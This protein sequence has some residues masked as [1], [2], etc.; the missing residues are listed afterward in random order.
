MPLQQQHGGHVV[1]LLLQ[2]QR[3]PGVRRPRRGGAACTSAP[4]TEEHRKLKELALRAA[5]K[6][7]WVAQTEVSGEGAGGE[8]WRADVLAEKGKYRVAIE[9]QWSSQ[10]EHE[11]SRRQQLYKDSGIRG[12]WLLRRPGF[13]VTRD[14]PAVCIGGD[15]THGFTAL[16]PSHSNM[17]AYH[18]QEPERWHQHLPIEEFFDAVFLERFQFGVPKDFRAV[19]AIR[20]K[21]IRCYFCRKET[22]V[23]CAAEVSF[24]PNFRRFSVGELGRFPGL[25]KIIL[26]N[27]PPGHAVG[28]IRKRYS[29]PWRKEEVSNGCI[30]CD[31]L[32]TEDFWSHTKSHGYSVT[33]FP[34]RISNEWQK[35]LMSPGA[36]GE[37]GSFWSVY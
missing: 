25:L 34:I 1:R 22:Q 29:E 15:L 36:G 23:I 30:H 18:R 7:G 4:E 17:S 9:V 6:H 26:K 32:C 5:R 8:K 3:V 10:P 24:E 14:L 37:N 28:E 12:L 16:I 19:V 20:T 27:L 33:E 13:P 2:L 21:S 11:T 35:A 31:R